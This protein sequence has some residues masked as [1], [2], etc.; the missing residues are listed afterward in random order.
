MYRKRIALFSLALFAVALC[1]R[2]GAITTPRANAAWQMPVVLESAKIAP[3]TLTPNDIA[4]WYAPPATTDFPADTTVYF[5]L[6]L[7]AAAPGQSEKLFTT[8]TAAANRVESVRLDITG[9]L[10]LLPNQVTLYYLNN[11]ALVSRTLVP[12]QVSD[13]EFTLTLS[14]ADNNAQQSAADALPNLRAG[15]TYYLHFAGKTTRAGSGKCT[16]A[17][18]ED[19][20]GALHQAASATTISAEDKHAGAT[21]YNTDAQ[22]AYRV[23]KTTKATAIPGLNGSENA[24]QYAIFDANDKEVVR[25]VTGANGIFS[26]FAKARNGTEDTVTGI[27][28]R[29]VNGAERFLFY[30]TD[31]EA[32]TRADLE[33]AVTAFGLRLSSMGVPNDRTFTS[34]SGLMARYDIL[35]SV[36][37]T[38]NSPLPTPFPTQY[39]PTRPP[40]TGAGLSG[41]YIALLALGALGLSC[42]ALREMR[43]SSKK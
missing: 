14:A 25:L 33:T 18:I 23:V 41:F 28:R 43:R 16:A 40:R 1:A 8:N 31:V 17:I 10:R 15:E 35:F 42:L 21:I 34:A 37:G 4:D 3:Q 13:S 29:E 11:G 32:I 20:V 19:N 27:T 30:D 7:R 36:K 24:T 6:R 2:S 5:A 9:D 22:I 12:T 38:A 39:Y 26:G